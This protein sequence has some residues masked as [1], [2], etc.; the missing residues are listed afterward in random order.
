M[1]INLP[2]LVEACMGRPDLDILY[3]AS[4][5]FDDDLDHPLNRIGKLRDSNFAMC[6]LTG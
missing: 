5:R 2:F 4:N 6:Q 1:K 3:L